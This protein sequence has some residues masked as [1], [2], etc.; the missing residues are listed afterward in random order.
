MQRIKKLVTQVFFEVLG[1]TLLAVGIKNFAVA[2]RIP[3]VGF[4]GVAYLVNYLLGIP[5]GWATILL[6]IPVAVL[7]FRVVG[8]GFFIRSV[9]CMLISSIIVDYIAPLLPLYQ[10]ERLLAAIATGVFMGLGVAILYIHNASTG[11]MDFITM[12]IK[13]RHPHFPLGKIAL[14]MDF[15]VICVSSIVFDDMDGFIYGLIVSFIL[16]TVVDKMIFGINSGKLALVVTERGEEIC[17]EIGN[18]CHRGSTMLPATGGYSK[19]GKSVVIS[20]C[21]SKQMVDLQRVV[22]AADPEAFTI[23]L[24]SNEVQGNGF[25]TVQFGDPVPQGSNT[26]QYKEKTLW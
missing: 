14:A 9:R 4:S 3:L 8:K 17:R 10:G 5:I 21:S 7:C 16:S 25:H 13:V 2:A 15:I 26:T 24:G 1:C 11:G 12:S 18:V 19:T 6:N 22:K 23:I 20:A